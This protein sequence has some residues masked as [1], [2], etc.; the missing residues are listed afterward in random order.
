[1]QSAKIRL[2][3]NIRCEKSKAYGNQRL[4][5]A[6]AKAIEWTKQNDAIAKQPFKPKEVLKEERKAARE[7]AERD[8]VTKGENGLRNYKGG[9]AV[10]LNP[11][12]YAKKTKSN[13]KTTV[14]EVLNSKYRQRFII[15]R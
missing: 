9:Y 11:A 8:K 1:M 15:I 5:A 2:A 14:E 3:H 13:N 12:T 7:K 4:T 10:F 6:Q